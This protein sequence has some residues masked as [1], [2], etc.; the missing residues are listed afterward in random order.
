MILS[1]RVDT[2]FFRK[3]RQRGIVDHHVDGVK[4]D[5]SCLFNTKSGGGI[6]KAFHIVSGDVTVTATNPPD[7]TEGDISFSGKT[8]FGHNIKFLYSGSFK[9]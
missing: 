8:Y 6:N 3:S 2:D 7:K 9:L 5:G 1:Q 4:V